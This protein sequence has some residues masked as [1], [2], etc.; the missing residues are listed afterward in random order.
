MTD[1]P[2]RGPLFNCILV[3]LLDRREPRVVGGYAGNEG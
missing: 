2:R 1:D 3:L